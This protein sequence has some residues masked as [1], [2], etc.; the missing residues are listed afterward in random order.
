MSL[1]ENPPE[2]DSKIVHRIIEN[3]ASSKKRF[4]ST[5][6]KTVALENRAWRMEHK[7]DKKIESKI[8]KVI[9][10]LQVMLNSVF[11]TI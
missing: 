11:D 2:A 8:D 10:L 9:E 3:Q 7:M 1:W 5:Q 6:G 4:R